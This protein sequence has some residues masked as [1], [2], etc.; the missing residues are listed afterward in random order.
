MAADEI[1]QAQVVLVRSQR[2]HQGWQKPS[3]RP[4]KPGA[5]DEQ[6]EGFAQ[7]QCLQHDVCRPAWEGQHT[8]RQNWRGP[9]CGVL[10]SAWQRPKGFSD[11]RVQCGVVAAHQQNEVVLPA[12]DCWFVEFDIGIN[13][14]VREM[15]A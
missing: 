3:Y 1:E 7:P 14:N 5:A 15:S 2:R 4:K 6:L 12:H 11:R 8:E 9:V 10:C 13:R